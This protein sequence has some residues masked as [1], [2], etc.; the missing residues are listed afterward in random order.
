M[1]VAAIYARKSTDQNG[2]ADEAK[3]VAR[4]VEHAKNYATRKGWTVADE[5]VYIDDGISGAE[6]ANRPGFVRLMN[7]L[8]P[9]APFDALVVSELSRLGR[10]QLE[11]GYALKQLSQAGVQVWSYLEDREIRLDTPTD[12]FMMAAMNFAA[13]MERDKAR[14]RTYDAM[15]RKATAG[16]VTGG[17]V[18]GY[19]NVEILGPPDGQGRQTRSHVERRINKAEEAVVVRIFESCASGIGLTRTAKRLNADGTSAPRPQQGRP[20][21]W[22]AS[23]VRQILYRE[24]YRGEVVWNKTR[25]RNTWGQVQASPRP[26][27]EWLRTSRPELRVVSDE[28]WTRAHAR[29]ADA[30]AHYLRSTTGRLW[31]RP[32]RETDSKYLLPGLARCGVCGGGMFAYSR[33]QARRRVFFYA[34]TAHH[35]RGPSICANAL[36]VPMETA[37]AAILTAIEADVLRA[38]VVEAAVARAVEMLIPQAD[39]LDREQTDTR[40]D[41]AGVSTQI[42]RLTAAIS[43]S[44]HSPALLRTLEE[45]ETRLAALHQTLAGIDQRRNMADIDVPD[46]YRDLERRLAEWQGLLTSHIPQ[47]RQILRALLPDPLILTPRVEGTVRRYEFRGQASLGKVLAGVMDEHGRSTCGAFP[48]GIETRVTCGSGHR[49]MPSRRTR[50]RANRTIGCS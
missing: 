24:L 40:A 4:Q 5:H 29:L 31:G 37:N 35:K 26:E 25:K 50:N 17:R 6:F 12:K 15:A 41:L 28:L 38:D 36:K 18:F 9:R 20:T 11:T 10:E 44:G 30:R 1:R 19:D 2:V 48:L 34:C 21:G 32:S 14:Q 42:D 43:A 22:V 33:Q 8:A 16:H 46:L 3:S 27:S 39:A 13:E 49:N 7:A 47:A 23:S 45:K